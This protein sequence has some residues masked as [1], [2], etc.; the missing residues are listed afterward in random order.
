MAVDAAGDVWDFSGSSSTVAATLNTNFSGSGWTYANQ[1]DDSGYETLC[2][3]VGGAIDCSMSPSVAYP[4]PPS[5]SSYVE[6]WPLSGCST[7]SPA[8]TSASLSCFGAVCGFSSAG[9][10]ACTDQNSA[11][12]YQVPSGTYV[13]AS[14]FTS[15]DWRSADLTLCGVTSGGDVECGATEIM[16]SSGSTYW[17]TG[18]VALT[19]RDA[20]QVEILHSTYTNGGLQVSMC[21]LTSG[22]AVECG[23]VQQ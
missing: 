3:I 23:Y 14:A 22:G 18:A 7:S 21:I 20:V 2:G 4:T 12:D 13:Q 9:T 16:Y 10:F 6:V 19:G 8:S 17:E 15:S 1:N 11:Y 5:G